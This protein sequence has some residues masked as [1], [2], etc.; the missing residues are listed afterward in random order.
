TPSLIFS[1]PHRIRNMDESEPFPGHIHRE[2]E[3][4]QVLQEVARVREDRLSR[5]LLLYGP[6]GIG[7]TSLVRELARVRGL[8]TRTIW[9]D[10]IDVDDPEVWLRSNLE[11]RG[12]NHRDPEERYAPP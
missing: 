4:L 8:E 11:R 2:E 5:A 3:E 7:K 12:A 1:R 6:G 9:A 10:P